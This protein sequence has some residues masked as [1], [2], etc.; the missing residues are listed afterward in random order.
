[1]CPGCGDFSLERLD[2]LSV[3]IDV[4]LKSLLVIKEKKKVPIEWKTT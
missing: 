2:L 4:V 3:N 1:M